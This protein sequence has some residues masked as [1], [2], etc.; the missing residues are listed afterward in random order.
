M[1][2]GE[3][4][5]TSKVV[6]LRPADVIEDVSVP[7]RVHAARL[8]RQYWARAAATVVLAL[9]AVVG[10][11]IIS[12]FFTFGLTIVL[13]PLFFAFCTRRVAAGRFDPRTAARSLAIVNVFALMA[14]TVVLFESSAIW[15]V[16]AYTFLV[17]ALV[18]EIVGVR[19]W[20][21]KWAQRNHATSYRLPAPKLSHVA[22]AFVWVIAQYV[23]YGILWIPLLDKVILF[24]YHM[25]LSLSH[26]L[27]SA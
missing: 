22:T 3:T 1:S 16:G 26:V 5:E 25:I 4:P 19:T 15:R 12:P 6:I 20:W 7:K 9:V 11:T 17:F 8:L 13:R 24:G 27:G 23:A 18:M 2:Y 14:A 10:T 21:T